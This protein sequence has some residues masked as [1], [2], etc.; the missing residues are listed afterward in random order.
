MELCGLVCIVSIILTGL[1]FHSSTD[2]SHC[3]GGF[4]SLVLVH[5]YSKVCNSKDSSLPYSPCLSEGGN[6]CPDVT[7]ALAV[8]SSVC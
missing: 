4:D 5:V 8:A 1:C 7:A 3:P 2:M 6:P